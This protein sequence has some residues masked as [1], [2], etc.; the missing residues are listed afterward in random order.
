MTGKKFSRRVSRIW[1]KLFS[2]AY[3]CDNGRTFFINET[4]V[5]SC[6]LV[7][8]WLCMTALSLP[9]AIAWCCLIVG[10]VGEAYL[11]ISFYLSITTYVYAKLHRNR[12]RSEEEK[13][14]EDAK[15]GTRAKTSKPPRKK[16]VKPKNK[17]TYKIKNRRF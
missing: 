7:L 6:I 4:F 9:R 17:R 10:C 2:Y 11:V 15:N 14:Y 5:V 16:A 13:A 1:R 3:D 12:V 8:F